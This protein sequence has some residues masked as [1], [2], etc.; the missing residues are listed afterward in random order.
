VYG[1]IGRAWIEEVC[2]LLCFLGMVVAGWNDGAWLDTV[3]RAFRGLKGHELVP[4]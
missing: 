1:K 2:F 4:L 3:S